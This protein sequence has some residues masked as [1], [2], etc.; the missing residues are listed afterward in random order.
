MSTQLPPNAHLLLSF[1]NRG[2]PW[3][4]VIAEFVDN[5]FDD[6]AGNSREILIELRKGAV[7][8]TDFG[9]GIE[10][11]NRLGTL[12]ASASYH[13]EGNIGQ[14][15]VGAKAWLCKAAKLD[16]ETAHAGRAHKHTFNLLPTLKALRQKLPEIPWLNAY[17][18]KGRT[19]TER[20][21]T[22][23]TLREFHSGAGAI[24]TPALI[25]ELQKRYWPGL[26]DGRTILIRD[27][28]RRPLSDFTVDALAPPSWSD[29][30]SFESAVNG[31]RYKATLG[32]LSENVGAY[33]GLFVG[34][35]FRNICVEKALP[36]RAV[37]PRV[38]GQIELSGD[39]RHALSNYKDEIIEDREALL[40]DIEQRAATILDLADEYA[41]DLRFENISLELEPVIAEALREGKGNLRLVKPARTEREDEQPR[42]KREDTERAEKDEQEPKEKAKAENDNDDGA[43]NATG[44]RLRWQHLGHDTLGAV[45]LVGRAVT[46]TLNRDCPKLDAQ[47]RQP[48]YPGV[49]LAM[50]NEL[51]MKCMELTV[52]EIEDLFGA[53]LGPAAGSENKADM[54]RAVR[55]WWGFVA[56]EHEAASVAA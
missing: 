44:V 9:R 30:L 14:Y 2:L 17:T 1:I 40:L 28:R 10:D 27:R 20:S 21:F 18:G 52:S 54:M 19:T 16:V 41:E 37:P 56:E 6:A 3:A 43:G 33:S 55:V 23:L 4:K 39:W 12:G 26:L 5:A 24:I 38:H 7:C 51:A 25:S 34:F 53:M 49:L 45:S 46:V 32:V 35:L 50:G 8:I 29:H 31:R 48:R 42:P 47:S 15:G 13:H 11:L 36:N 22:R